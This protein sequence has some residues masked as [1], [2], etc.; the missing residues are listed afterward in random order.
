MTQSMQGTD[1]GDSGL[2][3]REKTLSGASGKIFYHVTE[4]NFVWFVTLDVFYRMIAD[5]FCAVKQHI[6]CSDSVFYLYPDQGD[7]CFI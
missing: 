7:R 1:T 3:L 6:I 2:K 4:N 5:W